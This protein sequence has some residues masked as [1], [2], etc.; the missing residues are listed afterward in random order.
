MIVRFFGTG[1]SVHAGTPEFEALA[2]AHFDGKV[3]PGTR[4]IVVQSVDKAQSSCGFGVPFFDYQGERDTLLD[5]AEKRGPEGIDAY[6]A[7]KNTH[8]QDGFPTGIKPL[9]AG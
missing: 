8:S 5:W 7:E 2:E 4:Q 1:R 3:L 9:G 6:W